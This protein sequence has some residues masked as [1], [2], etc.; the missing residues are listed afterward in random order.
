[1]PLVARLGPF[2]FKTGMAGFAESAWPG[3]VWN[4]ANW[5]K[6]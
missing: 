5:T 2:A 4:I 6:S 1:M 3:L